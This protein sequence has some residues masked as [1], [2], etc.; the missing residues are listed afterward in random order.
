MY[1]V[2]EVKFAVHSGAALTQ[3]VVRKFTI[4]KPAIEY[5]DKLNRKQDL[6]SDVITSYLI[7]SVP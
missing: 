4:R 7:K 3:R 6:I 1:Q 2:V 5:A